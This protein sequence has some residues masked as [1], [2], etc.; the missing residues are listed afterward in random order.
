[1]FKCDYTTKEEIKKH[2]RKWPKT[3]HYQYRILIVEG[4][5]CGKTNA[6]LNLI[7][8]DHILIKIIYMQKIYSK[9]NIN[10]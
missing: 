4:S 6:L 7:N 9:Q 8:N 3:S 1:M 10:Y 5:G 2:N